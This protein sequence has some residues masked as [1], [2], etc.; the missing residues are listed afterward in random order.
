MEE[1]QSFIEQ[2]NSFWNLEN[3]PSIERVIASMDAVAWVLTGLFVT[4]VGLGLF[5]SISTR[6]TFLRVEDVET[7]TDMLLARLKQDPSVLPPSFILS[8]LGAEA[9]LELL[10]HGDRVEDKE[11]R[12]KWGSIRNELL[13][14][15]GQQNAFVPTY[16]LAR[17]YRSVDRGEPDSLRIRRTA[18]IHKLGSQRYL[19]PNPD[20]VP[21]E[22]RIRCHPA[23]VVGDLG[24]AGNTL[25]LMPDEPAP[26][27]RGPLLE[28]DPIEFYSLEY[29]ELHLS[30]RRTPMTGGGFRM[31][32]EKRRNLWVVVDEE[33]EWAS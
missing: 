7:T 1:L 2:L 20:G 6:R 18:L 17:Y 29:A 24:F 26:A 19:E 4:A 32:L 25:W 23:E 5:F 9:T 28:M 11:W 13:Y 31:R 14:L 10:E 8:R 16:T 27:P 33:I 12:Y 21:G 3:V 15:L 22:L 30:I